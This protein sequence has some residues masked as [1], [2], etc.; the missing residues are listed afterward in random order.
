M[1]LLKTPNRSF[2]E[3][4]SKLLMIKLVTFV[5]PLWAKT[6]ISRR[7]SQCCEFS[8][9]TEVFVVGKINYWSVPRG[10]F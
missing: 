1:Q 8:D 6:A 4:M 7:L 9:L 5:L 3:V 10:R 2:R